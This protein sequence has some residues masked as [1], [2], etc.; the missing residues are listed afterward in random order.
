MTT[1][2]IDSQFCVDDEFNMNFFA[3]FDVHKSEILHG[4]NISMLDNYT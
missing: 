3:C 2:C 4:Q 1:I